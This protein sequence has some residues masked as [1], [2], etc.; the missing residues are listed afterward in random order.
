LRKV[1]TQAN[2][3]TYKLESY[4]EDRWSELIALA[5]IMLDA[6]LFCRSGP[7]HARR[8]SILLIGVGQLA[9]QRVWG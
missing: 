3:F 8:R 4:D 6:A 5:A 2:L 7:A 9:V 1:Q